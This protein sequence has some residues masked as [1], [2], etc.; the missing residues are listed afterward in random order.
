MVGALVLFSAVT[1]N[2][3]QVDSLQRQKVRQRR[4]FRSTTNDDDGI[5]IGIDLGTTNSAVAYL[6]DGIPTI[7]PIPENGRTMPSLVAISTESGVV[8]VGEQALRQ[9]FPP[10]ANVKRVIVTGG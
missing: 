3:F 7:I 10:Y 6:K 1:T 8:V 9:S 5:G 2:G 4:S